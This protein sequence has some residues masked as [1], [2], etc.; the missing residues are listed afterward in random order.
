M[1]E[2]ILDH[3]CHNGAHPEQ[4]GP[5]HWQFDARGDD[6]HYCYYFH[7]SLHAT[8]AGEAVVDV[9]PDRDLLPASGK[10]F[11]HHR[12]ETVWLL[13]G[14]CWERHPLAPDAPAG[15][16]RLRVEL[17]AGEVVAFSR[18][19]PYPYSAVTAKV[20]E[21]A[22]HAEAGAFNLGST[23]EGREILA[24]QVGNGE[25]QV[26]LLGGQHPAEFGG[27]QA[28]LGIADWLLSRLPEARELRARYR[29]TLVPILNPDGNVLGRC[30]YN[31]QGE[32]LYRAFTGA[33]EGVL[34][35]AR[36]AACLWQWIQTQRPWLSL[37]FHSYTKPWSS[38]DAPWEGMYTAPDEA[39]PTSAFR[40][41]QRQVDDLLAWQTEGLSLN[42]RFSEHVPASLE[43]QLAALGILTGF[44][45]VQDAVGPFHQRRTGVEVLRAALGAAPPGGIPRQ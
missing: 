13:R 43:Y 40:E 9:V 11:R 12:P 35:K 17:R 41:A 21:L 19:R 2:L 32:D 25:Q 6:G 39:F 5:W 26:L 23:A 18:M 7:C 34:P 36:E 27:T 38:G 30:G 31:A 10:S 44:Y 14:N 15:G 37:N 45:E 1:L 24:L 29:F 16:V 28:V 3:E 42:R 8:Q 20:K 33:T 22:E 4:L